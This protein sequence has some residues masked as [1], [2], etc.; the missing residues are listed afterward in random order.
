M[1]ISW[2]Y[3]HVRSPGCIGD[4]CMHAHRYSRN[5][6]TG[7][8]HALTTAGGAGL[9]LPRTQA[10]DQI[11]NGGVLGFTRPVCVC[12]CVCVCACV[13]VVARA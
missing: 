4:I 1:R 5:E 8:V 11:G 13:D 10:H 12:V 3:L 6:R 7:D 2:L 9:D